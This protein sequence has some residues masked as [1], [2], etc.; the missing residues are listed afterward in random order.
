MMKCLIQ[1]LLAVVAMSASLHAHG[2]ELDRVAAVVNDEVIT[3][4]ELRVRVTQ[5]EQ[6]LSMQGTPVPAPAQLR[7]QVLERMVLERIQLQR[8][9]QLAITADDV[10]LDRAIARIAEQNN[11]TVAD[12]PRAL[13]RDGL[14]WDAF[15]ASIRNE[16][17]MA[18]LREREIEPRLTVSEA[19]VE[20]MLAAGAQNAAGR[21]YLIQHIYLR[22]SETATPD[23][24]MALSARAEDLQRQIRAGEDFAK[25]AA[26]YSASQDAMQGGSLDWRPIERIPSVFADRLQGMKKG[27][28]SPVLRTPAGLHIFRLSDL[29]DQVAQKVEIEQTHARH[30]LIRTAD[31]TAEAQATRR[32]E[33]IA[34]R[35]RNGADFQDLARANSSDITS[36][37]GGDL[38]WVSPG[39]TVPEF[40]RAMNAL[41]P[42]EVSGVVKTPFGWHLIQVIERRKADVTADQRKM[43]ARLAVRERKADEAYEDWLRQLR[44]TAYVEIKPVQ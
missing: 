5:A 44:D 9:K 30:I 27:E 16:M 10:A 31:V 29:R 13:E 22:A 7:S 37:K 32:L 43:A 17:I 2:A 20:A 25:L 1:A 35:I 8:A 36:T 40:E 42:G 33:D 28:V 34:A 14:S 21:E 15:R 23:Q 18:R 38:G 11:I 41:Q 12:M 4:S 6:Q 3:A 39:D 24:W 26:T 19:E